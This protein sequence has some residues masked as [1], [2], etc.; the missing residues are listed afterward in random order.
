MK[1]VTMLDMTAI[2]AMESIVA[3]LSKRSIEI[4]ICNLEN[5]MKVKLAR[6]GLEEEEGTMVYC[7]NVERAV[8]NARMIA[9]AESRLE[10]SPDYRQ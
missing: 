8:E 6:A 4:V 10:E 2:V 1:D 3:D 9:R 7:S 5:R